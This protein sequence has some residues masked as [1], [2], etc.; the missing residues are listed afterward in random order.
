MRTTI[1]RIG[2]SKGII[3]PSNMLK[4]SC[5]KEEVSL[6]VKD[7]SLLITNI[8]KPREVWKEAFLEAGIVKEELLMEDFGN[9][10]DLDEWVW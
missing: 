10:F 4:R 1:T 2:N 3:I 9:N 7:H 5:F 8:K 6:E